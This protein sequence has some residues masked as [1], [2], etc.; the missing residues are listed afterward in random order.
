MIG[1]IFISELRY[2]PYLNL[3]TSILDQLNLPYEVLYWDREGME[4]NY[5]VN[6]KAF[7]YKSK[8]NVSPL[9]KFGD[10]IKYRKWLLKQIKQ[11][12]YDKLILLSTLSGM[13]ISDFLI[14]KYADKYILDIRDYSYENNKL[15]Y[16]I[17]KKMI[18]KSNLTAISSEGFKEFLP[19]YNYEVVHNFSKS[20]L[21][22]RQYFAK[23]KK[24]Q[25]LNFVFVGGL[26]YFE[27]QSK[28]IE[29]LGNDSRFNIVYHGSGIEED[30]YHQFADENNIT[31]IKFT[32][33]YDNK[34][35]HKLLENA[36]ILNNSYKSSKVMEVQYAI[37]NKYYDGLIFGI[38]QLSEIDT[39]KA[40]KIESE[41]IGISL[42]VNDDNFS[43][44]LFD[45]Y[46]NI[47]SKQFNDNTIKELEKIIEQ[48]DHYRK[49]IIRF[50]KNDW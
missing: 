31:N 6:Y 45:Y 21:E 23:K 32:G 13:I 47:D 44:K 14:D 22:Y 9:N 20:E 8:K 5:P 49:K 40:Q 11:N 25:V 27:H 35:K 36:D 34:D 18:E 41:G 2:C 28:I 3:Y 26:R 19:P 48:D 43:D 46:H 30:R 33:L 29:K 39:Y 12:K 37:S 4:D 1:L 24:D 10:F 16:S 15:F 7:N 17:E 50:L 38:P 42:D